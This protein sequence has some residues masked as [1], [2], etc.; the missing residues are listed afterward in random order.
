[1]AESRVLPLTVD[2]AEMIDIWADNKINAYKDPKD[3]TSD[4]SE[5]Q[6]AVLIRTRIRHAYPE[7]AESVKILEGK[8]DK[9]FNSKEGGME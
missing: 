9:L 8:I 3:S 2:L 7:I 4:D 6:A 5:Y 1:M